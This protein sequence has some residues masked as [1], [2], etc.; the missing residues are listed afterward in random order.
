MKPWRNRDETSRVLSTKRRNRS[1]LWNKYIHMYNIFSIEWWFRRFSDKI[2]MASSRFRLGFVMVSP[3]ASRGR[4]S[5][6]HTCHKTQRHAN[7]K[8]KS[9][10]R[11]TR[12]AKI[13]IRLASSAPNSREAL[14]A[15]DKFGQ[16]K[17]GPCSPRSRLDFYMCFWNLIR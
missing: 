3:V 7:N 5:L 17:C 12:T 9:L 14:H 2:R 10:R 16:P 1:I 11:Q 15:Q 6:P 13:Q 4:R 8:D